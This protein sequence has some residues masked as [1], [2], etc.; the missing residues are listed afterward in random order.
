[1]L[2]YHTDWQVMR[3][4]RQTG[5]IGSSI[6]IRFL[7][8]IQNKDYDWVCVLSKPVKI[9]II[10]TT[11]IDQDG[12]MHCIATFEPTPGWQ[13]EPEMGDAV[14]LRTFKRKIAA[15]MGGTFAL[16]VSKTNCNPMEVTLALK[17]YIKNRKSKKQTDGQ[18][19][20]LATP[21]LWLAKQCLR[22]IK[23]HMAVEFVSGRP[24]LSGFVKGQL[25]A[26]LGHL[27]TSWSKFLRCT[28][29]QSMPDFLTGASEA[30]WYSYI[31]KREG[32][33][34]SL[35]CALVETNK[36]NR[37]HLLFRCDLEF[38]DWGYCMYQDTPWKGSDTKEST[39]FRFVRVHDESTNIPSGKSDTAGTDEAEPQPYVL[40]P[41]FHEN[42]QVDSISME[43]K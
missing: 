7:K 11:S 12:G 33:G 22:L 38:H 27:G 19:S 30:C 37:S 20:K 41:Y 14:A 13:D 9:E 40:N 4:I 10:D 24:L 15:F 34:I 35:T 31:V 6:Q 25:P 1:M 8:K 18:I 17:N 23:T 3:D 32:E 43:W 2:A 39:E 29:G 42:I 5:K 16:D 26:I 21:G 28:L 36:E